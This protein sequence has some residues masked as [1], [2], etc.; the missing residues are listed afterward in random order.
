M[1]RIYRAISYLLL[2]FWINLWAVLTF[3]NFLGWWLRNRRYEGWDIG[4]T[5][6]YDTVLGSLAVFIPMLG[7]VWVMYSILT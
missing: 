5:R 1:R 3:L 7:S 6:W 4:S 2:E